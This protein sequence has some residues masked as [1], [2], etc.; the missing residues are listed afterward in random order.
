MKQK[1]KIYREILSGKT[2]KPPVL[3]NKWHVLI[4]Q[5]VEDPSF[6]STKEWIRE[7]AVA[8]KLWPLCPSLDFWSQVNLNWYPDSLHYFLSGKGKKIIFKKI[9]EFKLNSAIDIHLPPP[10]EYDQNS[11]FERRKKSPNEINRQSF[12]SHG[13]KTK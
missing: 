13:K 7:M 10:I 12:F 2:Q 9:N 8:K 5:L 4:W 11:N 6:F 3:R 1:Y